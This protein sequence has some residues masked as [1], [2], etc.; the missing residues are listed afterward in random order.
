MDTYDILYIILAE[1]KKNN[2]IGYI[3]AQTDL[4][5]FN[6][7]FLNRTDADNHPTN[8]MSFFSRGAAEQYKTELLTACTRNKPDI[9][10]EFTIEPKRFSATDIQTLFARKFSKE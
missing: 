6:V 7:R 4:D 5:N 3:A 8:L 10:V 9:E 2:N 1:N